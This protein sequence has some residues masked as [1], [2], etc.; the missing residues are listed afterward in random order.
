LV[1]R[2]GGE[3]K[4]PKKLERGQWTAATENPDKRTAME[5]QGREK[6]RK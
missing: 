1:I 4:G 2:G 3:V 5:V 6:F